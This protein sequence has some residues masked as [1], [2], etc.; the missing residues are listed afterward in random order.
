MLTLGALKNEIM[1]LAFEE[2]QS[3]TE[4]NDIIINAINRAISIITTEVRPILDSYIVSSSDPA[5][6]VNSF[7]FRELTKQEGEVTFVGFAEVPIY[8]DVR[9]VVH[10]NDTIVIMNSNPFEYEVFYKKAFE[11]V[12]SETGDAFVIRIDSDVE[13]LLPLLASYY[14]W[15][16]DDERKAVMYYNDYENRKNG[17]IHNNSGAIARVVSKGWL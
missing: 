8:D 13:I 4:Y 2:K 7:N 16:D 10:N 6:S 17:I 1:N 12:K 3:I 11:R 9:Y 15:L 14:I 5:K